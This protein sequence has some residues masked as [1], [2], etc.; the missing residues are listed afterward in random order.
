MPQNYLHDL[1]HGRIEAWIEDGW[2]YA[3]RVEGTDDLVW[4]V[5]LG[6]VEKGQGS[7]SHLQVGR[8]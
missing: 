2:L 5:V 8:L 6:Q 7:S 1:D 4:H 3:R